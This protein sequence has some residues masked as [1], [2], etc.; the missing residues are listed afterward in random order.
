MTINPEIISY[1]PQLLY[2]AVYSIIIAIGAALIGVIGGTALAIL[3]TQGSYWTKKL[4][5]LYATLFRGTPMLIQITFL[6]ILLGN[7]ISAFATAIL[8]IGLNS[9]AYVSQIIKSGMS[10]V[11]YGQIEAARTL[12]V[13]QKDILRFIILPQAF[14][15]VLPT[16]GNEFITLIKD[17]SLASTI[18]VMELFTRA[19]IISSRTLD[20][21]PVYIIVAGIYL[22]ITV[23]LSL[24][25]NYI[26]KR[27]NR[28]VENRKSY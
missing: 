7:Y 4:V 13:A 23:T 25:I 12:G 9:A 16:L 14:K 17:T 27:L 10:A 15:I 1:L 11:P 18:T 2:G 21:I 6:Y 19:R 3:Q 22:T 8:A 24:I 26:E 5:I 20:H 28:H